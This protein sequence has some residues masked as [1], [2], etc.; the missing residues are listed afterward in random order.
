MLDN[1]GLGV[2]GRARQA[3]ITHRLDYL[4]TPRGDYHRL[5]PR[6]HHH[7]C[8]LNLRSLYDVCISPSSDL[9]VRLSEGVF[10][11]IVVVILVLGLTTSQTKPSERAFWFCT[12]KI[13]LNIFNQTPL[14]FKKIKQ[15]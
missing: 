3:S 6:K 2:W 12:L 10:E 14:F 7:H 9:F 11:V 5:H 1:E 13:N 8:S 4:L 15:Y